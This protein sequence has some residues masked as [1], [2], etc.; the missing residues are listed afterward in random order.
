[1]KLP[2]HLG[3]DDLSNALNQG[4]MSE[5]ALLR[6]ARILVILQLLRAIVIMLLVNFE[7]LSPI[8]VAKPPA[9][10]FV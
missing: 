7:S 9:R 10:S 4:L 3:V 1:M 5:D 8:Q 6:T 2:A